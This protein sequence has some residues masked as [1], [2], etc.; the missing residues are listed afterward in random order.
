MYSLL[1][2]LGIAACVYGLIASIII[3][4]K[5]KS[6]VLDKGASLTTVKHPV[7]ANPIFIYYVIAPVLAIVVA[8]IWIYVAES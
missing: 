1:A 4:R 8:M 3:M 6:S 2:F 7:I 5:H